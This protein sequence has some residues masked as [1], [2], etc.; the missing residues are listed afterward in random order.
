MSAIQQS[1]PMILF[2]GQEREA[3]VWVVPVRGGTAYRVQWRPI[4]AGLWHYYGSYAT[5]PY[6]RDIA[7]D[8]ADKRIGP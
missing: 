5:Y 2:R 7:G 3:G 6:A 1:D 4:G 8:I